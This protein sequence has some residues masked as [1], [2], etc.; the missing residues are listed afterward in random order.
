MRVR[1]CS[2]WLGPRDLAERPLERRGVPGVRGPQLDQPGRWRVRRRGSAGRWG[3]PGRLELRISRRGRVRW[4]R[5]AGRCLASR[6][7]VGQGQRQRGGFGQADRATF[8]RRPHRAVVGT[9]PE[10]DRQVIVTLV[11]V[12][13]Q[14]QLAAVTGS[15]KRQETLAALLRRWLFSRGLAV[16][17]VGP[18][19]QS[20]PGVVRVVRAPAT[21]SS[22]A[23]C[24][25]ARRISVAE[26][27]WP[28]SFR[29]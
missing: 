22:A 17:R 11:R 13:G 25:S 15:W 7:N 19:G 28:R 1:R 23:A 24:W 2:R 27:A 20:A 26:G 14:T 18:H 5:S 29:I 8:L 6:S 9:R 10:P 3:P 12:A 4:L 16:L 21:P